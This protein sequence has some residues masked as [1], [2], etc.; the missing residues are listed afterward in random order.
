VIKIQ[1]KVELLR[2]PLQKLYGYCCDF[3]PDAIAG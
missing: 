1:L 2:H 3:R